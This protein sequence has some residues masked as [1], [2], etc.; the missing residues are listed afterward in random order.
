MT[1]ARTPDYGTAL[2]RR[3]AAA[4]RCVPLA[5]GR[6][7]PWA[8]ERNPAP[9]GFGLTAAELQREVTRLMSDDCDFRFQVWEILSMFVR[10]DVADRD[11][12]TPLPV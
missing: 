2:H 8:L 11:A 3:R 12:I 5:D 10:P 6:R 4:A 9:T 7:D 1:G